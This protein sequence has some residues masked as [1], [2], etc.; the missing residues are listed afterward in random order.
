M[1][2]M[3][4]KKGELLTKIQA[5]GKTQVTFAFIAG[6]TPSTIHKACQGRDLSPTTFGKILTALSHTAPLNGSGRSRRAS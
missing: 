5:R 6:V 4:F 3:S 1:A 2:K